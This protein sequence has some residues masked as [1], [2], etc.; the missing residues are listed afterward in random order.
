M[1][2][3]P[4]ARILQSRGTES[5]VPREVSRVPHRAARGHRSLEPWT[6]PA[7]PGDQMSAEAVAEGFRSWPGFPQA[8]LSSGSGYRLET[9]NALPDVPGLGSPPG[10]V[11]DWRDIAWSSQP[12]SERCRRHRSLRKFRHEGPPLQ[13]GPEAAPF[14]RGFLR[15]LKGRGSFKVSRRHALG[16]G[17]IGGGYPPWIHGGA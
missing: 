14:T 6:V 15:R 5:L 7:R 13:E 4:Q 8:R 11:I 17:Q 16:K 12:G 3:G 9:A 2:R 1:T 10:P